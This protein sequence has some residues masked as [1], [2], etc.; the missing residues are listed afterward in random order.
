[1]H[2]FGWAACIC[3]CA[4]RGRRI[5]FAPVRRAGSGHPIILLP[6]ADAVLAR[7]ASSRLLGDIMR[8]TLNIA[9]ASA[10]T[11]LFASHVHAQLADLQPGR[12]F[13]A[14]ANWGSTRCENGDFGDVDNDGDLDVATGNGGDGGDQLARIYINNGTGTFTDET[15]TRFAGFP[16]IGARD[17]EFMDVENDGDLDVYVS[18][19]TNGGAS[20]GQA[21]RFFI[22]KGGDQLGTVGFYQDETATRWGTLSSVPSL[23]L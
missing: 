13:T 2:R 22:N 3:A 4:L 20:A 18:A 12:N 16:V 21:S 6:L 15:S 10:A 19:H 1:M 23:S 11:L 17:I 9:L 7:L 14:I 8:S 5:N